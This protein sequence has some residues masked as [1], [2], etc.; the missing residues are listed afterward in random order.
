MRRFEL[1]YR[2]S[3]VTSIRIGVSEAGIEYRDKLAAVERQRVTG[4]DL[5]N[6]VGPREAPVGAARQHLAGEQGPV[7]RAA[8][9]RN[10]LPQPRVNAADGKRGIDGDAEAGNMREVWRHV[11]SSL[12]EA[13][14]LRHHAVLQKGNCMSPLMIVILRFTRGGALLAAGFVGAVLGLELW[15]YSVSGRSPD[16]G[17]IMVLALLMAGFLLLARSIARE[18]AKP[19]S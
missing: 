13:S 1:G 11:R 18:L 12:G 9:D 16:T 6:A 14:I 5:G 2:V 8:R 4:Q 10:D 19:G 17:F 3:A 15:R 7:Q